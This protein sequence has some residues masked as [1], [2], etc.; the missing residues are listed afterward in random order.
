MSKLD[1]GGGSSSS[2]AVSDAKLLD[3][4]SL[5]AA[6]LEA[7]ENDFQEV[8]A[9]LEGDKS[10]ERFRLEYEKLHRA[11]KKSN[12]QEKKLIKKCRELNAEIINNAAKVQTAL[13]LSQED[14]ASIASLKKEMEKA[15]KMVD[16][17]HEKEIRAKETIAQ[18]KDEINNLSRLVEQGAGLSVGQENMLKEVM[19]A[20]EELARANDEHE[21][22]AKKDHD[23]LQEL[24]K[25]LGDME[26]AAVAQKTEIQNLKDQLAM[27]AVGLT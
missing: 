8:L 25:R 24:H 22:N 21:A 27:K 18:L 3:D 12:G 16:A 6:S 9:E 13:K 10:L 17:S 20:K 23:R 26:Q 4:P 2:D 14:Q 5:E 7:L 15:W 1:A 11:L 19:R